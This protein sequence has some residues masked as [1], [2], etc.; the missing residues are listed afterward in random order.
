MAK[1]RKRMTDL[2]R[3]EQVRAFVCLCIA[4]LGDPNPCELAVKIDVSYST[5]RKLL[6]GQYTLCMR[7]NTLLKL[8][9][10]AGWILEIK[11][12]QARMRQAG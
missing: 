10:A 9:E 7:A 1:R 8:G 4:L 11:D 3:L 2:E 6:C 5:A 12:N